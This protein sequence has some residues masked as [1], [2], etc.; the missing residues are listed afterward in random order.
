MGR[1]LKQKEIKMENRRNVLKS[2]LGAGAVAATG[3][4]SPVMATGSVAKANLSD[5]QMQKDFV[6]EVPLQKLY[7]FMAEKTE[8]CFASEKDLEKWSYVMEQPFVNF[9]NINFLMCEKRGYMIKTIICPPVFF[10]M[11]RLCGKDFYDEATMREIKQLGIYAYVWT[12]DVRVQK[13]I[14]E[15][16]FV[17]ESKEK[18]SRKV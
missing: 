2:M 8:N 5:L 10:A 12:A 15:I 16:V 9:M 14:N 17:C 6:L 18:S 13:D 1:Q 4:A 7:S 3:V 11:L